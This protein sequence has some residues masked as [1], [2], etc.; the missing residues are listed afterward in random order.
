MLKYAL[1]VSH[2]KESMSI[3]R[4]HGLL[5]RLMDEAQ[6]D[7][8]DLYNIYEF[9]V[10]R[11]RD[12]IK[13][14]TS[15]H[16]LLVECK[17]S[18]LGTVTNR[19]LNKKYFNKQENISLLVMLKLL[20]CGKIIELS[21]QACPL[22]VGGQYAKAQAEWVDKAYPRDSLF[23]FRVTD[24]DENN[25]DESVAGE[26]EDEDEEDEKPERVRSF[27][28]LTLASNKEMLSGKAVAARIFM[29]QADTEKNS[30]AMKELRNQWDLW[31]EAEQDRKNNP[32]LELSVK[33]EKD[34]AASPAAKKPRK[35]KN[36]SKSA[37]EPVLKEF[38]HHIQTLYDAKTRGESKTYDDN[39]DVLTATYSRFAN[40]VDYVGKKPAP[41]KRRK[42]LDSASSEEGESSGEGSERTSED[43]GDDN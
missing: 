42:L 10:I 34:G 40:M 31:D 30:D 15:T 41:T 36:V 3:M 37:L 5:P 32:F 19:H 16:E 2:I 24:G 29:L 1:L 20:L 11:N 13:R 27:F 33:E 28:D 26:A 14:F 9:C 43:D 4:H 21:R 17:P 38:Q 8:P 7:T 22:F 12:Y 25:D 39:L 23:L 18:I 35:L 6:D